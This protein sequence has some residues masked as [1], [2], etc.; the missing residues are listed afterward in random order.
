MPFCP[1][2][3]AEYKPEVSI[4][5]DCKAQL[6]PELIQTEVREYGDWYAVESVPNELVGNILRGVL[7]AK[8]IPVY[9][10]SHNV[11]YYGGVKGNATQSEWGDVLVPVNVLPQAR[12]SLQAYF[13]SLQEV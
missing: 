9:L 1:Q 12:E 4:C 2:C 13:D 11:P 3:K 7:E 8:G 5:S 6:V 10:R